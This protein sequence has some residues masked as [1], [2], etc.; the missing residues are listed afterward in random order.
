MNFEYFFHLFF[1][2]KR[3]EKRSQG[4]SKI[5][6]LTT[7]TNVRTIRARAA[8]NCFENH[9][10]T[11]KERD[12]VGLASPSKNDLRIQFLSLPPSLSLSLPFS[13][14][15]SF[16]HMFETRHNTC[17]CGTCMLRDCEILRCWFCCLPTYLTDWLTE[18]LVDCVGLRQPEQNAYVP[19]QMI[20]EIFFTGQTG[21]NILAKKYMQF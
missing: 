7:M 12:G 3:T 15:L 1:L 20:G 14:S 5:N 2:F 16:R 10:F 18:N 19:E 13:P 6:F 11:N 4:Y 9:Q 8:S 17:V 21:E